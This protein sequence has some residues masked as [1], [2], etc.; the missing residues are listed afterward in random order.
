MGGTLRAALALML[1]ALLAG[2]AGFGKFR[3]YYGPE[4]TRIEVLKADRRMYLMHGETVLRSYDIAL[5]RE[6]VGQKRRE[7][8]GRTPEG[9]YVIDRRNPR[10]AFHLSLGISYPTVSQRRVARE[11]GLSPGGD[12]FI[13]GRAGKHRGRGPDWTEGC[14][15]VTDREIE[16]I[17]A[18]VRV[19]TPI[20]IRP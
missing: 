9:S 2:C 10:S 3:T 6:P 11:A 5:G 8:D 7:G 19:G 18:M 12:I 20:T 13:H 4:V 16:E 17:Y 14:I 1:V 15:A